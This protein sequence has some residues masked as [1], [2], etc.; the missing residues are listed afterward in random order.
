MG[1]RDD[2]GADWLV[3]ER[4]EGETIPRKILRDD[5]WAGARQALTAQCA[6]GLAAIHTIEPDVDRARSRPADPAGRPAA[7]PGRVRARP[8]RRSSSACAGWSATG[9]RRGR[10]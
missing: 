4:L 10:G 6:P 9:R 3:V 2:L 5:E 7:L 8:A 1:V